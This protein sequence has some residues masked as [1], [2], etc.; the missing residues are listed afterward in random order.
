MKKVVFNVAA[1]AAALGFVA[2]AQA[3]DTRPAFLALSSAAAP[4]SADA[5][6]DQGS[7]GGP[8]SVGKIGLKKGVLIGGGVLGAAGVVTLIASGNDDDKS[9]N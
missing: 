7:L 1:V 5:A 8:G 4:S 2:A 6:V 9:P 3:R